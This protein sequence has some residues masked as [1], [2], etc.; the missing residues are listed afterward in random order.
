VKRRPGVFAPIGLALGAA[1]VAAR[2]L[3][4]RAPELT[5][6]PVDLGAHFSAEEV[7]RGRRFARPQL[8]ISLARAAVD[9][10]ALAAL[11]RRPPRRLASRIGNPVA[12]G[13]ATA[14]AM[15][16]GL[17]LPSLPLAALGR[18]RA[19]RVGLIT[20]SWGG[21]AVDLLKAN[22]IQVVLGAGAGGA[23]VAVTRRYP[24][25]WWAPAA[26][27]S[28][29]FGA[30][31]AAV[32]PVI[33][34]PIFNDFTP[35]PEGETRSDVLELAAAAGVKV[36]EVYSVDASRRTTAANAYVAGLGPTKRVVLF[37][38]LL[39]RYRRDEVR[40][41]V[42]HELAH[43]RGHDVPRGVVFA[44]IV[45]PAGA[46]AVQRL[47]LLLCAERGSASTLPAL[48]FSAGLVSAPIGLIA[49]GLSR[50]LERRAD[51]FSLELSSA[52]D[53]F[54]SFER[55]IALQNVADLDPPRWVTAV[56]ATHPSTAQ[57]IGAALAYAR[58]HSAPAAAA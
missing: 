45:A 57:R 13:A 7:H 35:L 12:A 25:S 33:L 27:G 8:A 51:A 11:V 21:W 55:A 42:A 39:D 1:L 36:G 54:V 43:V 34:D 18:R 15:S 30:V 9:A 22:A 6:D 56:L 20:Q 3:A 2:L 40:V 17:S 31:L 23:A 50:A 46:L 44:A 58:A 47:S 49:N 5:P 48:A 29:A 26:A 52:P 14:A 28:V 10:A 53:A 38:T 19:I 37:D 16:V 24:R 41:V 4:P 32:A